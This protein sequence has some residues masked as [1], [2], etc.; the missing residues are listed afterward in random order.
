M[1]YFALALGALCFLVISVNGCDRGDQQSQGE[2]EGATETVK[3]EPL[4][5]V[6]AGVEKAAKT[7]EAAK[8]E[9]KE[10]VETVSENTEEV[11][12]TVSENTEEAVKAVEEKTGEVAA[13]TKKKAEGALEGVQTDAKELLP[14]Y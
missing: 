4:N 6:N 12:E 2:M 5:A 7:V 13:K 11:I 10:V 3:E 14:S 8:E 1:K 9:V